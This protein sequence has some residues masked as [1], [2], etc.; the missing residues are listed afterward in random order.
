MLRDTISL[1][2]STHI[3]FDAVRFSFLFLD[4]NSQRRR[5]VS[6][7]IRLEIKGCLSVDH[8]VMHF[9]ENKECNSWKRFPLFSMGSLTFLTTFWN[10]GCFVFFGAVQGTATAAATKQILSLQKI[11]IPVAPSPSLSTPKVPSSSL[12]LEAVVDQPNHTSSPSLALPLTA[13]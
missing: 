2:S 9:P 6:F 1:L 13:R 3:P 11:H 5:S 7:N 10:K 4:E 12:P 8:C